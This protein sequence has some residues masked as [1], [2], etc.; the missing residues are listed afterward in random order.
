MAPLRLTLRTLLAYLDDTLEPSQAKLIG[1]KIAESEQA[2]ELIERIKTVTRRRRITTPPADAAGGKQHPIWRIKAS[3]KMP[4]SAYELA[5]SPYI[6]GHGAGG[7]EDVPPLRQRLTDRDAHVRRGGA[8]LLGLIGPPAKQAVPALQA[9]LDDAEPLVRVQTAEALGRIE[10]EH[11]GA[12]RVLR[13][14]LR[15]KDA[16]V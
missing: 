16:A 13:A 12:L 5:G 10:A 6:V 15:H 9:A 14:L 2:Q 4:A 3:L 7:V 11:A 1:Q 8:E